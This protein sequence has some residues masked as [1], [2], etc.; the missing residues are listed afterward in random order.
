MDIEKVVIPAAGKGTRFLPFTKSVP[1]EM[2]PLLEKPSIQYIIEEGLQAAVKNYIMI[3]SSGKNALEDYFDSKPDLDAFL[4]ENNKEGLLRGLE[5]ITRSTQFTYIRQAEALGLGHAV[6][7]AEQCINKEYFGVMLPDDILVGKQSALGQLMRIARQEKGSVIAVQ[8]VPIDCV[9]SYG[10]IDIKQ[11]ITPHL[12][13]ISNLIEKPSQ[14]DAPSN[15]AIIGRYVLSHKVFNSLDHI[16]T[17]STGE[18]QLTDAIGHMIQNNEK[19]FAYKV[20]SM[21]YDVGTPIGWIKAIIGLSL[22][23]PLYGPHVKNFIADLETTD[24]YMYNQS[25]NIEHII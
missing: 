21:R 15:L 6:S 2:L 14:K 11:Q 1:K 18:I 24:S 19:V 12:F 4:Q 3:T 25:K 22:Q 7:L 23:H 10:I 5:K 9:S 20:Q 8:E 17:Y 16:S 13:Q